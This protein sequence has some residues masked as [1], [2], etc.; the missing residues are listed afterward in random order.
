MKLISR[1]TVKIGIAKG[2]RAEY[3]NVMKSWRVMI[4]HSVGK[5]NG[6]E[7]IVLLAYF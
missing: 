1:P 4:A 7:M 5:S 2:I 3:M 6:K